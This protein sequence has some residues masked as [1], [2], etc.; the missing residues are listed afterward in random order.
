M[1][2]RSRDFR[3]AGLSLLVA[4]ALL[5]LF[6]YLFEVFLLAFGAVLLA[7]LLRAPTNWIS[8]KTRIGS[9]WALA[10]VILVIVTLLGG[11]GWFMGHTIA[12]QMSELSQQLPRMIGVVRERLSEYGVLEQLLSGASEQ[13][14]YLSRGLRAVSA[15]FGALAN[16]VI[17]LFMAILLAAQPQLYVEGGIRLVPKERRA[18]AREVM[19]EISHTLRRWVLGQLLLMTIV[20][21][22]TYVGLA[23]LGVQFA[24]SLAILAGVLTFIPFIGPLLAG[25]IAVLVT[26]AQGATLALYVALLYVA[27]QAI[28]GMFEPL[29][30]RKAVNLAPAL[31]ILVQV[32]L[33][34]LAG[35]LGIV[36]ATP[37]AAAGLVCVRMLYVE[38][39][40]GDSSSANSQKGD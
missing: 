6:V 13:R 18:R 36:L 40:L 34:I 27:V 28:E 26:L 25:A 24:L 12:E 21:M 29:V 1:S 17:L 31:L 7:V 39:M 9:G 11:A 19:F 2:D 20:A 37:L 35:P 32:V 22:L 15:T 10:A 3:D 5:A 30:Q 4:V 8:E 33:G 14:N 38:D 23:L 16:V